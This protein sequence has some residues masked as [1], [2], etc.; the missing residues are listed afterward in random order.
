MSNSPQNQ[1]SLEEKL[2]AA[3]DS[4]NSDKNYNALKAVVS[5]VPAVGSLAVGFFD[6]YIVPPA[7]QRTYKFLE[8]LVQELEKLKSKIESV[9]FESPVFVTTFLHA[10]QI[11][12]RT[13]K[14]QKLEALRNVVLNSSIPRALEDDVLA[15]FLNWIDGFTALHIS[16]LKHLHYLDR[17]ALEE[18]HT[19]F[20]MLEQNRAIYNQ[21]L[22]DLADRG[23][24]SLK[25]KYIT[26]EDEDN[27]YLQRL[28]GPIPLASY[29][30]SY[31]LG[32]R[33]SG[34]EIK[35]KTFRH[36]EDID[37]LLKNNRSSSQA[38]KTTDL[39]KQFIKFIES[40]SIQTEYM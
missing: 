37:I 18:L 14:E 35:M 40:P 39:G 28:G 22:K 25:E 38:S 10:S 8:I 33:K 27:L 6:S 24:I 30:S 31:N 15:M 13:H 1:D 9:D 21:V 19:Y 29:G 5:S 4:D 3:F 36:R 20:P 23:L 32:Q 2:K 7:T 12:C 16:T 34:K 17:Y 11:A 26:E